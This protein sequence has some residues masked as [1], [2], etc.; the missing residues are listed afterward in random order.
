[1]RM[2]QHRDARLVV[3]LPLGQHPRRLPVPDANFAVA[4]AARK[5]AGK[6]KQKKNIS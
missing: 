3:G 6:E 4:V 1:M 5:V 2:P